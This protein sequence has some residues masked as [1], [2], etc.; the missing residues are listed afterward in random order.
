M[1]KNGCERVRTSYKAAHALIMESRRNLECLHQR[2]HESNSLNLRNLKQG[3]ENS[4]GGLI[5]L[6]DDV[7]MVSSGLEELETE[8]A[9]MKIIVHTNKLDADESISCLREDMTRVN[10]EN[11]QMIKKT[12]DDYEE[13][14]SKCKVMFDVLSKKTY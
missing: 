4:S 5:Q 1:V 11:A 10:Q 8:L 14:N 9:D 2:N 7:E 3:I 13:I 6:V 12:E